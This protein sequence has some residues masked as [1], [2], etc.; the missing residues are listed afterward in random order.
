MNDVRKDIQIHG[1]IYKKFIPPE[2]EKYDGLLLT[3]EGCK[4]IVKRFYDEKKKNPELKRH[5]NI[6]H[7]T[8][9]LDYIG[10]VTDVYFDQE[11]DKLGVFLRIDKKA[12]YYDKALKMLNTENNPTG[13]SF[14][15]GFDYDNVGEGG[16][17]TPDTRVKEKFLLGVSLVDVPDHHKDDTFVSGWIISDDPSDLQLIHDKA[18]E[19]FLSDVES[20]TKYSEN[21]ENYK[22][23]SKKQFKPTKKSQK[24]E[25]ESGNTHDEGG[26]TEKEGA[27]NIQIFIGT[28]FF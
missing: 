12:K 11:Q 5:L 21:V 27:C 26:K 18:F 15:L 28:F 3:E 14:E 24:N 1:K 4:H 2:G 8:D 19:K 17:Q 10:D 7:G 13:L 16:M 6:Q 9:F 25:N 20:S 22:K 23:Y